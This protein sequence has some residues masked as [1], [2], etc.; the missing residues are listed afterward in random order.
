[1]LAR[2]RLPSPSPLLAPST[3]PPMSTNWTL[4]G[5]T[6]RLFASRAR[7]S[8]RGSG[9][10]ATPTLGSRVANAYGAA[11]APPPAR[12]LYSDDLP[13]LGRPT[14]PKRSTR[15]GYSRPGPDPPGGA[16]RPGPHGGWRGGVRSEEHT[17]EL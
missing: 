17:A 1:M 3:S 6:F 11:R 12:A 7:A 14:K 4:A 10:L 9:T 15:A 16:T 2:K 13:A 8:S 5:T